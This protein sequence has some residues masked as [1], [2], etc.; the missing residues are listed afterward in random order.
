MRTDKY[1]P[2]NV[3]EL[4]KF[5][6]LIHGDLTCGQVI[7]TMQHNRWQNQTNIHKALKCWTKIKILKHCDVAQDFLQIDLEIVT[8][9]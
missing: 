7:A 6:S 9:P 4:Q 3:S 1:Y 5:S 8:L 2:N